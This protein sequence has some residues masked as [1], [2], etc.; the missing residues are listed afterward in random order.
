MTLGNLAWHLVTTIDEMVG[1]AGLQFSPTSHETPEPDSAKEILRAYQFSSEALTN[2]VNEQW[3]DNTLQEEKDM[4]GESWSIATILKVLLT[5]QI[6]HRGQMT[7]LMRQAGLK[8]PG[9]YGPSREEWIALS[10]AD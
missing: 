2:A 3:S 9:L 5:H 6:H 4:Y 8:V 1:K 7:V 10:K